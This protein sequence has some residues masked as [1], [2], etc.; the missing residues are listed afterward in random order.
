MMNIINTSKSRWFAAL[1]LV[2]MS[3]MSA[4]A[5]DSI[6]LGD[7]ND[8]VLNNHDEFVV[9]VMLESDGT[10]AGFSADLVIPDE[11]EYVGSEFATDRKD[12]H[13]YNAKIVSPNGYPVLRMLIVSMN[14]KAFKGTTGPLVNVTLRL[15]DDVD[16]ASMTEPKTLTLHM[17][18]IVLS[19]ANGSE[20]LIDGGTADANV[21]LSPDAPEM[22]FST[23]EPRFIM[24]PQS[25]HAITFALS[26]EVELA[27]LGVDITIPAG[28]TIK[29]DSD[30]LLA[31]RV[32]QTA[33][34]TVT[35]RGNG[36]YNVLFYD[37]FTNHAINGSSGDLFTIEVVAPADF[38]EE[39]V[40]VVLD[41][42][43][44]TPVTSSTQAVSYGG[45]GCSVT[46]VNGAVSYA[47][48]NA[49]I[50]G[51]NEALES[52]LA[53]IAEEAAD[54]KDQF[55]G[56]EISESIA[57][58]TAAVEEAYTNS[59]LADT[60]DEV[61][62]PAAG[63]SEAIAKLVEDAKAAQTAYEVEQARIAAN[64]AAYQADLDAIAA[65][66]QK[67]EE[68]LNKIAEEYP[69]YDPTEA[70]QA[71]RDAIAA[72]RQ[73]ADDN[74]AAVA[75]EG[76]YTSTLDTSAIETMIEDML[77]AAWESGVDGIL[78]DDADA[79]N[80]IYNLNG[81][82]LSNPVRGQFNIIVKGGKATK[83]YVK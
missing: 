55:P 63:I 49:A 68:A 59:T 3:S 6:T 40:S 11:L 22:V 36:V 34:V 19:N 29:G 23:N 30:V 1:M 46:I 56:T 52:A 39:T 79:S 41:G 45:T 75:E 18:N 17:Q 14:R 5:A 74:L 69:T 35:N 33:G 8:I 76:N 70:A 73:A 7:G 58:L 25:E 57:A 77:T 67:L 54:V 50:A 82:R 47:A 53:T 10:A 16:L 38:V 9:P 37:F 61:M 43:D 24:N 65:V 20:K 80:A 26:N 83:V 81:V 21:V 64:E 72:A 44:A 13:I 62:A 32:S 4:F 48:A 71:I 66:E 12:G 60:Y 2:V 51:L 42:I 15:K 78:I 31:D 27:A 28:F